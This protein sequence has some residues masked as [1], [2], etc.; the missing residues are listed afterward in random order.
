V[1]LG[2]G[3]VAAGA[4]AVWQPLVGLGLALVVLGAAMIRS[5]PVRRLG[6]VAIVLGAAFAIAGPNLALPSARGVFAFRVLI[7]LVGLAAIGYLLMD[8]RI[9]LPAGLP[10]PALFLAIWLVWAALSIGWAEDVGG[11]VRWTSFLAMYGGLALAIPIACAT[12]RRTIILLR[13]LL[14][15]FAV[16]VLIALAELTTGI[17][18]PTSRLLGNPQAG[19]L[20][21]TSL[22]GNQNNLATYL[23]LS[24]P[25]FLA[26]PVVFRDVRLRAL[27]VA[28]TAISL[29]L[30]LETGSKSNLIATGLILVGLIA[31]VAADGRSRSRLMVALAVALAAAVVVLPAAQGSGFVPLP[32]RTATKLNF[33]VI[34]RQVQAGT[35]SGAVRSALLGDGLNLVVETGGIGV[36]AGNA[37]TRVK[38]LPDFPGVG[39]LHD[40]WLEVLVD[41]GLIGF[42]LYVAF[43]LV[44]FRGQLRA[45][46]SPDPLV[47]YLG[48]AGTLA[49]LGFVAGSLGPS[50]VIAF[51]PMW[52]TFGLCMLA[53][54]LARRAAEAPGG[55]GLAP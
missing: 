54:V 17:R 48:L 6:W 29:V 26:L 10:Q 15:T 2:V 5:V 3:V 24:L 4:F 12:R 19:D 34:Q 32:K 18:L 36:G 7:V 52:V 39:N 30:L 40:W 33:S 47:R 42:A 21:A 53:M 41:G 28:G 49:L 20:G 25:Y 14:V 9:T 23:T 27:G 44:L 46:G 31:A 38:S 8:G 50:T 43:Y 1:A 55:T 37:E 35:G 22:F 51:A 16:A 13:V 45:R 11:A